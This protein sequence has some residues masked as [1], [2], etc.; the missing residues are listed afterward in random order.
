MS[1]VKTAFQRGVTDFFIRETAKSPVKAAGQSGS[2]AKPKPKRQPVS[3][4]EESPDASE[5]DEVEGTEELERDGDEELDNDASAVDLTEVKLKKKERKGKEKYLLT[6][7]DIDEGDLD[8]DEHEAPETEEDRKF[9]ADSDEDPD[10]PSDLEEQKRQLDTIDE[11]IQRK[12]DKKW[13][14]DAMNLP[15]R[16]LIRTTVTNRRS[17]MHKENWDK[18]SNLYKMSS[19]ESDRDSDKENL[20]P[21]SDRDLGVEREAAAPKKKK[22]SEHRSFSPCPITKIVKKV[23]DVKTIKG[24]PSGEFKAAKWIWKMTHTPEKWD[25]VPL[26][27][28]GDIDVESVHLY[29][30]QIETWSVISAPF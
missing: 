4:D 27:D 3:D 25:S 8:S 11:K 14:K 9:I 5:A 24:I 22:E 28:D 15:L 19:D 12:E 30:S 20:I 21:V 2:P 26:T 6:T 23:P 17:Q 29:H 18:D 1:H 16:Q 13:K 10:V 7:S